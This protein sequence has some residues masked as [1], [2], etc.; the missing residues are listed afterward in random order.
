MKNKIASVILLISLLP[1][2][3]IS[4]GF[5]L[6]TVTVRTA[7][8]KTLRTYYS[9][10]NITPQLGRAL[11]YTASNATADNVLTIRIQRGKYDVR[12][13]LYL[14]SH[15]LIDLNGSTLCNRNYKKGNIFKSPIDREYHGYSSLKDLTVINGTLD[16]NFNLNKSCIMR[17]CHCE[18]IRI[19]N[20]SFLNN[21]YSHHCELA[22]SRNVIF[23]NCSFI[24]Q[25]SDL[26][27][28]SSEALQLDILDRVHFSGFRCYDNT[29]NRDITV[30][31]CYFKNVYRGIG[32]HNFFRDLYQNNIKIVGCTFQNIR[33]CAVS[34][35]NLKNYDIS[36][37]RFLNCGY[38]VFLRIN[39]K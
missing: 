14:T 20:V 16:G 33:D 23:E 3:F 19:K 36:D 22:A 10:S 2:S 13:T 7:Q 37:N 25:V 15:T 9:S 28:S 8:G 21:Y 6:N 11:E 12:D 31:R 35:V 4:T 26:N 18:N 38:S 30:N 1:F 5:A 27:V 29:M 32:T 24:G 17:L 34:C 39:G